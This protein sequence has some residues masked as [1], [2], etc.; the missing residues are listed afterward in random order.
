MESKVIKLFSSIFVNTYDYPF[1]IGFLEANG[2]EGIVPSLK[3]ENGRTR[4]NYEM[5]KNWQKQNCTQK[6]QKDAAASV[7]E[8]NQDSVNIDYIIARV[9]NH[10]AIDI[11]EVLDEFLK[12]NTKQSE[13]FIFERPHFK[14]LEYFIRKRIVSDILD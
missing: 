12:Y 10:V 8:S 1:I 2:I 13:R 7:N 14:D 9:D 5:F 3:Q 11:A 6:Q 4:I